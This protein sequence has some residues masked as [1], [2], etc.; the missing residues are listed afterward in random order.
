MLPET[1]TRRQGRVTTLRVILTPQERR[2]LEVWQRS[3]TIK[4]GLA[5]RGRIILLMDAG[6]SISRI[7]RAIPMSRRFVYKWVTRFL[8]HGIEGLHDLPRPGAGSP[9]TKETA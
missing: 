4:L 1:P 6:W 7:A 2:I 9:R 5:N 8:V 3:T